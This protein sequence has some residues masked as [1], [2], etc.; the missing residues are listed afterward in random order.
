M[1]E[2]FPIFL[3]FSWILVCVFWDIYYFGDFWDNK[4]QVTMVTTEEKN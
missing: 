3:V 1:F 4:N 2:N